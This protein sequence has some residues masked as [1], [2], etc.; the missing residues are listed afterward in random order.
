MC[1]CVCGTRIVHFIVLLLLLLPRFGC[2]RREKNGIPPSSVSSAVAYDLQFLIIT[3]PPF[4][5]STY[6]LYFAA[7]MLL[8]S[9]CLL[10]ECICLKSFV[11]VSF[12]AGLLLHIKCSRND[13]AILSSIQVLQVQVYT[14]FPVKLPGL[15]PKQSM[16]VLVVLLLFACVNVLC[17]R[18]SLA[19]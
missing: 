5:C 13:Y 3:N 8:Y 19:T 2:K 4:Q 9:H 15:K 6:G 17:M 11:F 14:F 12:V 7:C 10:C 1:V 18:F 16:V